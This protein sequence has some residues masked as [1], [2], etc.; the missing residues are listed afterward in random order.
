MLQMLYFG[1]QLL[2]RSPIDGH[3]TKCV[4]VRDDGDRAV[5]LFQNAETV[6]RV[7]HEQ[8]EWSRR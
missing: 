4:Y 3:K 1:A 6:A 5:V 8:L 7:D 2:Y